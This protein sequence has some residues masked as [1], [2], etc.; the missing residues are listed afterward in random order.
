MAR[1]QANYMIPSS[2]T[3]NIAGSTVLSSTNELNFEQQS[4]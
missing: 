2:S 3:T 4:R 1:Q